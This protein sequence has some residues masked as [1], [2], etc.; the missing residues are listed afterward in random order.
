M[1]VLPHQ[2]GSELKLIGTE[3]PKIY[4]EF[5]RFVSFV[6]FLTSI[7]LLSRNLLS[8]ILKLGDDTKTET[9]S[10]CV[11][12]RNYIYYVG[13]ISGLWARFLAFSQLQPS[14][15]KSSET[16]A[17]SDVWWLHKIFHTRGKYTLEHSGTS[18]SVALKK[19]L[20]FRF[21]LKK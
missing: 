21:Y 10:N 1:Q 14:A 8:G 15:I 19:K 17:A 2:I 9:W 12:S 6:K 11:V 3:L 4:R 5:T 13:E 7:V 18:Y 20:S 16:N